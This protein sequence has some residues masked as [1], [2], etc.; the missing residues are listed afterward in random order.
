MVEAGADGGAQAQTVEP[1]VDDGRARTV[2]HRRGRLLLMR[3]VARLLAPPVADPRRQ[4]CRRPP[5]RTDK[6]AMRIPCGRIGER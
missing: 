6:T 1:C 3:G 4:A 5:P 2:V